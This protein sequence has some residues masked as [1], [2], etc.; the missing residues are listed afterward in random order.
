MFDDSD[1]RQIAQRRETLEHDV[2]SLIEDI[3]DDLDKIPRAFL[4]EDLEGHFLDLYADI[5]ALA[6]L[7]EKSRLYEHIL[8][9]QPSWRRR[10]LALQNKHIRLR[11][12]LQEIYDL[13]TT[14]R[15]IRHLH[16][17]LRT[18]LSQFRDIDRAEQELVAAALKQTDDQPAMDRN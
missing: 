11:P 13:L 3:D 1:L 10:V 12:K 7:K 8:V 14:D 18:W 5:E 16:R 17:R 9:R 4:A 15:H 2:I 6:E